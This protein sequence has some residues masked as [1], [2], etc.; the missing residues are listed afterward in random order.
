MASL[1]LCRQ[2]AYGIAITICFQIVAL[3]VIF[4]RTPHMPSTDIR[5]HYVCD[6]EFIAKQLATKNMRVLGSSQVH[7]LFVD[8]SIDEETHAFMQSSISKARTARYRAAN[9]LKALGHSTV[10]SWFL[11]G[12]S[13]VVGLLFPGSLYVASLEQ[14][15]KLIDV[16]PGASEVRMLD[17]GAGDGSVTHSLAKALEVPPDSVLA[18]EAAAS[19]RWR[20]QQAGFQVASELPQVKHA[21]HTVVVLNVLDVTDDPV[22]LLVDAIRL[23]K[24]GGYLVLGLVLPYRP[25]I[26]FDVKTLP[27]VSLN[28]NGTRKGF[29]VNFAEFLNLLSEY[30]LTLRKWTRVP[31]LSSGDHR[32]AFYAYS[33][34]LL[35]LE[36]SKE[37]TSL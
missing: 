2:L 13:E 14:F 16:F 21:F 37:A 28:L 30:P 31:Y 15:R 11:H 17:I 3:I 9:I 6:L 35:V 8:M 25:K 23:L 5:A 26:N 18:V 36:H 29:E 10:G 12:K 20:L 24:P 33:E 7:E 1:S 22:Q 4:G 27:G 19:K 34:A 32:S